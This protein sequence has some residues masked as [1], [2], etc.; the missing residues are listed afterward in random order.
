MFVG[1][2]NIKVRLLHRSLINALLFFLCHSLRKRLDQSLFG[3]AADP[4]L[5]PAAWGYGRVCLSELG[6]RSP[7]PSM[8]AE[9]K[10]DQR[11][12]GF[13]SKKP[14]S[15]LLLPILPPASIPQNP[16]SNNLPFPPMY[17][18]IAQNTTKKENVEQ[19]KIKIQ[20]NF[21]Q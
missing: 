5:S 6:T 10:L 20:P 9:P 3:H 13:P 11:R 12:R 4:A 14:A 15:H 16:N 19:I 18:D 21:C 7:P 8:R 2:A 17:Y 1:P